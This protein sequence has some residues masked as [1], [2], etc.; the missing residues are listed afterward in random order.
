M[1]L[2]A[3]WQVVEF[4]THAGLGIRGIYRYLLWRWRRR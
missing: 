2:P 3:R 1:R 4:V